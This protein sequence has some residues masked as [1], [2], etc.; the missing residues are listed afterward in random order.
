METSDKQI[1]K[2]GEKHDQSF[3]RRFPGLSNVNMEY[4]W[5]G[6]LCLSRNS[7]SVFGEIDENIFAACCCNGLGTSKSTLAGM[8]IADLV[9]GQQNKFT[10][11]LMEQPPLPRLVPEP[12]MTLGARSH[13]AW[14]QWRAGREL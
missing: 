9:M 1:K 13:L 12:F 11:Q 7:G 8:L 14:T 4:R 2:I 5:G 10:K 3:R 6:H